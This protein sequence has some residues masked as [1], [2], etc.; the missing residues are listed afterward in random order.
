MKAA[1]HPPSLRAR[2]L[3]LVLAAIALVSLLQATTAYRSA[4][5]EADRM[6]DYHLEEV[7]RSVNAGI[8]FTPGAGEL[9]DY[10]VQI[11]GPDGTELFRSGGVP[12]PSQAVLG[13]SDMVVKGVRVRI[14]SLQTPERTIQI[15]QDLDAREQRAQLLAFNAVLPVLLLAPLLMLAVGWV[16][17]TSLRPLLRMRRQIASRPAT[18]LSPLPLQGV[19][20]EVQPLVGELNL[21]FARVGD[22]LAAQRNFVADAA[23]ELRSPLTALKLQLQSL[24][25]AGDAAASVEA[26]AQ[27][28][29]GIERAIRLVEQ[30][31]ALAR[32]EDGVQAQLEPVALDEVA[33]D[34]VAQLYA[35]AQARGIDLGIAEASQAVSVS[36]RRDAVG[37]L[38]R[39]LVE[40]AIKYTPAGGRIDVAT[41]SEAGSALVRVD[42]SGPGI[43][44]AERERVFDR[45]YRIAGSE[46]TGS[47][48]GLAIVQAVAQRF[49]AQVSLSQAPQ[50]G[51][52]RA[53]V[54]FAR[55]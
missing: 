43:P 42:D 26:T 28:Q 52:L 47:G 8:P 53:E 16:I 36:A 32:Q 31:L 12:L 11:W 24:Q 50:L 18:D 7:A 13:F 6:F 17:N 20:Q 10:S 44:P 39:N 45:F 5:R 37:L 35:L 41:L 4:L 1:G 25:R 48:L 22:L 30:L 33:R 55:A 40:N 3:W 23:H 38:L 49:D 2:L 15:A 34:T 19:P 9:R 51:G 21:L 27:L 46:Q 14:Y 54:R 29:E